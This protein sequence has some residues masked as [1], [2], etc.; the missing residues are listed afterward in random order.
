MIGLFIALPMIF[1][2]QALPHNVPYRWWLAVFMLVAYAV[3]SVPILRDSER[4]QRFLPL[5][6]TLMICRTDPAAGTAYCAVTLPARSANLAQPADVIGH[7]PKPA[8]R[9]LSSWRRPKAYSTTMGTAVS[10]TDASTAG[11]LMLY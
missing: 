9:P 1:F 10:V 4:A 5:A 3:L 11:T 8:V 2:G 7:F 6:Q